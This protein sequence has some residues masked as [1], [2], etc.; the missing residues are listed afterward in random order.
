MKA[1]I[2]QTEEK[3]NLTPNVSLSGKSIKFCGYISRESFK[4]LTGLSGSDKQNYSIS[5]SVFY[6]NKKTDHYRID[7][8]A[9]RIVHKVSRFIENIDI[10][11]RGGN[12]VQLLI[13]E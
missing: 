2:K 5:A 3:V 12:K 10:M 6:Q 13:N 8:S 7:V 4:A 11:A 9:G 1:I